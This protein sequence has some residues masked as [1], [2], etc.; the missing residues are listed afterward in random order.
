MFTN[1]SRDFRSQLNREI[2]MSYVV[3]AINNLTGEREAISS[4]RSLPLATEQMEKHKLQSR[5]KRH[6]PW[7]KFRVEESD[8]YQSLNNNE[9]EAR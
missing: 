1:S 4:P 6:Q 2:Y 5:Y 8:K 7:S 9:N 3:T